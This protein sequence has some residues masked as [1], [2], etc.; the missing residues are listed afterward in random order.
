MHAGDGP[1]LRHIQLDDA[2][3][4]LGAAENPPEKH[5]GKR[6]VGDVMDGSGHLADAVKPGKAP[7]D[8]AFYV[9]GH[10]SFPDRVAATEATASTIFW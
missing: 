7:P 9:H 1:R 4:R 8:G 6:H 3:M 2:R 5:A 10:A